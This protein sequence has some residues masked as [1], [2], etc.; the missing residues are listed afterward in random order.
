M[1]KNSKHAFWQALVFTILVFVLGIFLGFFLENSR[2]DKIEIAVYDSEINLLDEQLRDRVTQDFR[3]N[4]ELASQSLFDFADQIYTEALNL[5]E[6]DSA[7][8]LGDGLKAVHRR[9][10]L[11]R[12]MLWLES[13]EIRDRCGTEFH[14]VVYFYDYDLEDLNVNAE[15]IFLGRMLEDMKEKNKDK[16]LLIP[17]AGNLDLASI[18]LILKDYGIEEL[19]VILID[20]DEIVSDLITFDELEQKIFG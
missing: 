8:K 14:T 4:C 9:Y 3:V 13:I 5:E 10:D 12:M 1:V 17:I 19:P 7:S 18:D 20:E 6:Y 2:Y 11:L 15:Q 16:M